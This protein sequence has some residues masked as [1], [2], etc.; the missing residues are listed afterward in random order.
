MRAE[1]WKVAA[2]SAVQAPKQR[3]LEPTDCRAGPNASPA[4]RSHRLYPFIM[5]S[6]NSTSSSELDIFE[7]P[8][9]QQ[10]PDLV[11]LSSD[12]NNFQVHK[13]ILAKA[14]PLFEDMFTLARPPRSLDST[15]HPTS[16]L[17]LSSLPRVSISEDAG[18]IRL[19]LRSVYQMT[20]S[21]ASAVP[22]L[23]QLSRA[24]TAA[25]KYQIDA[26][27]RAL[28]SK[29]YINYVEQEPFR[30]Y[31]LACRFRFR[32]EARQAARFH[33][34]QPPQDYAMKDVSYE[35]RAMSSM[36]YHNL[37]HYYASVRAALINMFSRYD[38]I[39][40][41]TPRANPEI[42]GGVDWDCFSDA[43]WFSCK[44]CGRNALGEAFQARNLGTGGTLKR[45]TIPGW[46]MFYLDGDTGA[47]R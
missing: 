14:S 16:G 41:V 30:L 3:S 33:L 5:A 37:L 31:A 8:L 27:L 47:Q 6:D 45:S 2:T 11:L 25:H 35:V 34:T 12:G 17:G 13:T 28:Y 1:E 46:L 40:L 15:E 4:H 23:S 9:L 20:D 24:M 38:W 21:S 44:E 18:A 42:V 7:S 29:A 26:A 22:A 43:K 10:A 32:D 19:V 39:P 36:D